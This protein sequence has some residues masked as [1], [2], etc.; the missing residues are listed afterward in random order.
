[1]K[2][3]LAVSCFISSII[4]GFVF[5]MIMSVVGAQAK[6]DADASASAGTD[7]LFTGDES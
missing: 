4:C 5:G 3:F 1:M 6:A 2:K 7:A